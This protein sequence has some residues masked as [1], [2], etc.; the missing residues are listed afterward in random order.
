MGVLS[1]IWRYG[2]KILDILDEDDLYRRVPDVWLKEDGEVSSAAFQN[3]TNSDDMS[4]DL[5]RLTTPQTTVSEYPN[6]GVASFR[7][8]LAR[9]LGQKVLHAPILRYPAHSTVRGKKTHG[10]RR[11]FAKGSTVILLPLSKSIH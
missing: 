5:A 3:T 1:E 4:V 9:Q 2:M 8:A 10:I 7:A 6:C 11:K